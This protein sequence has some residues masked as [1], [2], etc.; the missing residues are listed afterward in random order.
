MQDVTLHRS[1]SNDKLG[2]TLCYE[3]HD[4]EDE[5]LS[6]VYISEVSVKRKPQNSSKTARNAPPALSKVKAEQT[7]SDRRQLLFSNSMAS[8]MAFM[9]ILKARAARPR[10][11][12]LKPAAH[13]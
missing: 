11:A 6:D 9:L 4:L 13:V 3:N 1:T 2:L 8:L 10:Y 5:D 7:R 12:P